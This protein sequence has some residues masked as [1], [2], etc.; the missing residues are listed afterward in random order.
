MRV[1]PWMIDPEGL[2]RLQTKAVSPLPVLE[3]CG[4][5]P[6]APVAERFWIGPSVPLD[7]RLRIWTIRFVPFERDQV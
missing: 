4:S 1:V 6:F 7:E 2:E 3:I 5:S